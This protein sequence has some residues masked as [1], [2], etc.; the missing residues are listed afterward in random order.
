MVLADQELATAQAAADRVNRQSGR[1]VAEGVQIDVR[2]ADEVERLLAGADACLSATPYR[3]NLA[4]TVAALRARTHLCDL[5]GHTGIARQQHQFDAEARAAGLSIIPN[6]G[7][8]PGMGTTLM[9]HATELLDEAIDVL[10]WDGG[11]PQA[12]RTPFNYLLTFHVAGL[13]NEYA[14]PAVFLR[15]WKV[16]EVEPMTELET[17]DFPEPIG[18][19]EAFV[20]GG[21]TDT[22]PWTFEGRLRTL[23]NLTLRHPGHYAQLRAF[24]D[25]GLWDLEPVRVGE[26]DVAPRDL[27]HALFEPK[28]T[29]PDDRDLVIVRVRALGKKDGRDAE[30][31]VEMID[32]H[33][34]Q[35]GFTAM[36]RG[37]GWSAAI[38][39]EMMARGQTPRGAGGVELMVPARAFV[40][41][42]NRRG[43]TGTGAP[44]ASTTPAG[45]V[46]RGISR[47]WTAAAA[48][49][50]TPP[51]PW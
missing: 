33:D 38:V 1:M 8:V 25:L 16:T 43:A 2:D 27:F 37:T 22:M 47:P 51:W 44:T 17:V 7:Q 6:C 32:Y 21:G 41:E 15:D 30:A 28:V 19:L 49:A 46:L 39:A 5:G 48:W 12:P 13:T 36:E 42:L 18:R 34:D 26:L 9:V 29:F 4:V 50:N 14:E 45:T 40:E 23:Q 31:L 24:Y 11:I 10:M 20:A 3:F 35:T